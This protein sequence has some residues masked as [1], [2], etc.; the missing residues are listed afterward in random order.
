MPS[1]K[2]KKKNLL[3]NKPPRFLDAVLVE[4][5]SRGW[6][7]T[8]DLQ[9]RGSGHEDSQRVDGASC[10]PDDPGGHVGM[11]LH[12]EADISMEEKPAVDRY[13]FT[14]LPKESSGQITIIPKPE[15]RG[16]WKDSLTKPPFGVTSAEVAIICPVILYICNAI[17]LFWTFCHM[18]CHFD[19]SGSDVI[20][21]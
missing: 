3:K 9:P 1:T 19:R 12:H 15:L 4:K 16:F 10:S 11:Q 13:S 17:S 7:F 18:F 14:Y 2:S 20:F 21:S 6:T 5:I 8:T